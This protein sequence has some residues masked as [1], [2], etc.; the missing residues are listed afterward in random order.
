MGSVEYT[1][2]FFCIS[3]IIDQLQ[4]IDNNQSILS[5]S[6]ILVFVFFVLKIGSHGIWRQRMILSGKD[7]SLHYL[8]F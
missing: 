1:T 4:S 7:I 8:F 5:L 2:P 6:N 3:L